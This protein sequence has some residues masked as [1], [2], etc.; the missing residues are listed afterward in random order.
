MPASLKDLRKICKE[1]GELHDVKLLLNGAMSSKEI[2]HR[3]DMLHQWYVY[4][5]IDG[6][7]DTYTDESLANETNIVRGIENK[8]LIVLFPIGTKCA[9]LPK[10]QKT[11]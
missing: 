1:H 6:T 3:P 4:H 10:S 9:C 11:I 5:E 7:E 8:A 2:H